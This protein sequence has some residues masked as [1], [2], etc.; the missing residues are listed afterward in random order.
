MPPK[1]PTPA[2]VLCELPDASAD[3][4][5]S[6]SPFFSMTS[7]SA[8]SES[9]RPRCQNRIVSSALSR[10]GFSPAATSPISA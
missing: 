2:L 9:D 8:M 6:F 7:P 5:P 3:G 4:I 1:T 10:P